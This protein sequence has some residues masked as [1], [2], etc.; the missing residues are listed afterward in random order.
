MNTITLIILI[1]ITFFWLTIFGKTIRENSPWGFDDLIGNLFFL[2]LLFFG[3]KYYY[4]LD[5][6]E[7]IVVNETGYNTILVK[8]D[9]KRVTNIWD[10]EN[11]DEV[12][13]KNN[14]YRDIFII[15]HSYS[16]KPKSVINYG[17]EIIKPNE[18]ISF[19]SRIDYIFKNPPNK[20]RGSQ[21]NNSIHRRY[22]L[23][24]TKN[25]ALIRDY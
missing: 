15:K 4:N 2:V 22:E 1:L 17:P 6:K 20:I 21:G 9:D 24:R 23:S 3:W 10:D 14:S 12:F 25:E 5:K 11:D 18:I 19:F 13:I 7:L 8:V 16:K